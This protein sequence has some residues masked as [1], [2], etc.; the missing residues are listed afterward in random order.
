[1]KTFTLE[2]D[3]ERTPTIAGIRSVY[4]FLFVGFFILMLIVTVSS[5]KY[6]A[7]IIVVWTI[8]QVALY[9][10]LYYLTESFQA[11]KLGD[12]TIPETISNTP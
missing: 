2:R 7:W 8:L 10:F 4:F 11:N 9:G 1:M 5:G 6:W 12:E 3:L